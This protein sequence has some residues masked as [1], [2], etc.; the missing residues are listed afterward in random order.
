[1]CKLTLG[2]LEEAF[3]FADRRSRIFYEKRSV[4][5]MFASIV[6]ICLREHLRPKASSLI[7]DALLAN[8]HAAADL[9]SLSAALRFFNYLHHFL[10]ILH[11]QSLTLIAGLHGAQL[12]LVNLLKKT[13]FLG[14]DLPQNQGTCPF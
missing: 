9:I 11:Y 10:Q 13:L 3:L 8:F 4:S 2:L 6:S 5:L 7:V 1:M 12:Y 14:R